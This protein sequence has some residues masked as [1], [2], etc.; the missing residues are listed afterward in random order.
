MSG[1]EISF[2]AWE[3]E[4]GK[5]EHV[6]KVHGMTGN[7][8]VMVARFNQMGQFTRVLREM[9]NITVLAP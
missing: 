8:L 6:T 9:A 2:M 3:C 4:F 1:M 5:M 7:K